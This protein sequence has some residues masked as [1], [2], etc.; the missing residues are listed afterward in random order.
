[1]SQMGSAGIGTVGSSPIKNVVTDAGTATPINGV[2]NVAS[3]T[4]ITS[5]E[6]VNNI[7]L[8]LNNS[9]TIQGATIGSTTM[10]TNEIASTSNSDIVLSPNGSGSVIMP[11]VPTNAQLSLNSSNQITSS[12]SMN[13]GYVTIG[14]T[15]GSPSQ[16]TLTAGPGI[17]ISNGPGSITI[18]QGGGWETLS[19]GDAPGDIRQYTMQPNK[20]YISNSWATYVGSYNTTYRIPIILDMPPNDQLS[21]GDTIAVVSLGG[22]GTFIRAN[23][24]Q[25]VTW[26]QYKYGPGAYPEIYNAGGRYSPAPAFGYG[27]GIGPAGWAGQSTS[28][29]SFGFGQPQ[30]IWFVV[31]SFDGPNGGAVYYIWKVQQ[32]W[33][34][35]KNSTFPL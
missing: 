2:V 18:S 31:M 23:V 24:N 9:I 16:S 3:S 1:M 10:D 14:S 32:F 11:N 8:S 28:P 22:G 20:G 33:A 12:S 7:V 13:N 15:S 29:E 26:A 25:L 17:S 21:V 5:Q 6:S 34:V 35:W 30:V 19:F 27:Y 4:N